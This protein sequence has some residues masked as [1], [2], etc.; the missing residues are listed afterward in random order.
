[1]AGIKKVRTTPYHPR[2][3]PVERFNRTLLQMLGTLSDKDKSHWKDFV[4]PLVHAYN[5]TK[6][7]TTGFSPY[8]L[9]Y[10][11]QPRLPIDLAF[12]LP[13][14]Q[15]EPSHS[16]YIQKLKTNLEESY[17][18]ASR[19]A[20]KTASR[21]KAR[22]DK[23]VTESTL[24]IGDRVLVRNVRLRGKH[25]LADKWEFDIYVVVNRTGDLP[26]YT[27]QPEGKNGPRRTLHRDLLLPCGFLSNNDSE[28]PVTLNLPRRPQTRNNLNPKNDTF[29][30]D[31]VDSDS[32]DY[33]IPMQRNL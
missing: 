10:G 2:G 9:M 6:N 21:N 28:E 33:E 18:I 11:R 12:S 31:Y 14:D 29:Q 24:T 16:Q 1:M 7:D 22:F 32:S 20:A 4:K 27:V 26:V 8:E 17:R 23:R 30:Q 25:K 5:C 15:S 13:S 19:N 3:N